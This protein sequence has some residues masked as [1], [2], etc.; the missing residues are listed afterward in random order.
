MS[1]RTSLV[2]SLAIVVVVGLVVAVAEIAIRIVTSVNPDTGMPTLANV[3]FLPYRPDEAA[4]QKSWDLAGTS[5]YVVRDNDL[6]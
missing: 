4:V 3:A 1:S 6:G 5:T 2:A